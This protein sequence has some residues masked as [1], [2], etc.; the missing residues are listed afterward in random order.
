MFVVVFVI[1]VTC[2]LLFC[3]FGFGVYFVYV[4]G[5]LYAASFEFTTCVGL[6]GFLGLLVWVACVCV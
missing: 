1:V 3:C 2:C 4:L 6:V 5:C